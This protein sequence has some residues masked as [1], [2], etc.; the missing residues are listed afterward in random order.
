MLTLLILEQS[1]SHSSSC[2]TS[3]SLSNHTPRKIR[4]RKT[5]NR[6]DQQIYRLK[7]RI[8]LKKQHKNHTKKEALKILKKVL[9]AHIIRFIESQIDLHS[10]KSPKGHRYNSETKAFALTLYHLS[11]KAYKMISKLFCLP[12]KQPC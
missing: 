2:Q 10:K 1:H 5:I 12:S 4:L 7:N 6:K 8:N 9:P 3:S 11:G